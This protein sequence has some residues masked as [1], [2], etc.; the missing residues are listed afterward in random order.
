[1][2]F[3]RESIILAGRSKAKPFPVIEEIQKI[4]PCIKAEFIYVNLGAQ[5]SVREAATAGESNTTRQESRRT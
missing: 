2:V 1:M 4:D 5:A 3:M